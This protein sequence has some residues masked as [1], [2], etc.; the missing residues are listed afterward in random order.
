VAIPGLIIIGLAAIPY[1]DPSREGTGSCAPRSRAFA[2]TVYLAG[3]ALWFVLI[4]IGTYC[5]GP[6]WAWYWP[7]EDQ[8]VIKPTTFLTRDLPF[9][10]GLPAVLVYFG[11]GLIGP[12][13][14]WRRFFA[15]LG[16]VRYATVIGLLLLMIA[17]PLKIVLRLA[18][19]VKYVLVTPW[20]NI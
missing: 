3:L 13:V 12:R 20:F 14:I 16:I 2:I 15:R 11:G 4:F 1:V 19:H 7:W 18:F 5:R 10:V 6:N 17:V 8:S 9:A